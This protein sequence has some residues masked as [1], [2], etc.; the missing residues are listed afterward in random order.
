MLTDEDGNVTDRYVYGAFGELE[1]R[2]GDTAN[3]YLF[4]GE[5][6]D[7]ETGLY[8]L[9]ARYMDP[10]IGRFT[11]MDEWR[12]D[13]R[14]PVTLHKYVY[15]NLDP[16]SGV[17]PS[18]NMSIGDTMQAVGGFT[19]LAL[20]TIANHAFAFSRTF[21]GAAVRGG[22]IA[23]KNELRRCIRSRGKRCRILVPI[24]IAGQDFPNQMQH[25]KDAQN[26]S[27]E[28]FG[29]RRI[30]PVLRYQKGEINRQSW[31][32]RKFPSGFSI[33]TGTPLGLPACRPADKVKAVDQFGGA[34]VECDEYPFNASREGGYRNYKRGRVSARFIPKIENFSFGQIINAATRKMEP[35]QRYIVVASNISPI[36]F[37]IPD[38]S[39]R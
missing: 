12:G 31:P 15:G 13:S 34:K 29:Q 8:Y 35:G 19:S 27:G 11:Q 16:V 7:A 26:G 4:T 21:V 17:D 28:H 25:I 39:K 30:S 33:M 20:R 32:A 14:N 3:A 36:S 10:G 37:F 1:A 22:T 9:R 38:W 5:Q 6:F 24:I 23:I 2:E 18:G